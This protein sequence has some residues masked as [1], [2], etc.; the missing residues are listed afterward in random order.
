GEDWPGLYGKREPAPPLTN[1]PFRRDRLLEPRCRAGIAQ[2]SC[3]D[4]GR[5]GEPRG[6]DVQRVG[7]RLQVQDNDRHHQGFR[8]ER[9]Y[10]SKRVALFRRTDNPLT[11]QP[12]DRP[13]PSPAQI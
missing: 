1:V 13:I 6:A 4:Y 9:T 11:P 5:P 10:T 2:K 12:G 3:G 8:P 7:A